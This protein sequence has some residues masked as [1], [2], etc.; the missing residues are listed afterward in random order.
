MISL[1]NQ[2]PTVGREEEIPELEKRDSAIPI[3]IDST[4]IL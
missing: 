2:L 4:K 1:K 3:S